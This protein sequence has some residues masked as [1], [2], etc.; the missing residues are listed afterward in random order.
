[1]FLSW[2][3]SYLP[4]NLPNKNSWSL[5]PYQ[6][7]Y[8]PI[9]QGLGLLGKTTGAWDHIWENNRVKHFEENQLTEKC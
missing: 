6:L 8:L 9:S 7:H 1:M 3:E 2:I 4:S 5:L